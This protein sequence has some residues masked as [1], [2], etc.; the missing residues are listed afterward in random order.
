MNVKLEDILD[1]VRRGVR[2]ALAEDVGSGDITAELI[3]IDDCSTAKIIT[4]EDAVFCGKAWLDEC[5]SA[6]GGLDEIEWQVADGDAIHANQVLVTLRGNTRTLLTGERTALN[7]LQLLSGV[8]TK[9][10]DYAT[11]LGASKIKILDTRKTLPGLRLAQKYAVAVGGCHNHRIGL[12]DAFLVKE[13]H[14]AAAGGIRQAVTQARAIAPGKKIEVE[15]ENLIE[16]QEAIDAAA[17]VAM[18][19]NFDATMLEQAMAIDRKN[20]AFEISGNLDLERLSA[21]SN[22]NIDYCSFGDLTKNVQSID[23]SMR[24][25]GNN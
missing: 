25:I 22:L 15:T 17:D 21:I 14:I 20:T 12:Y 6:L 3:P 11:R 1:D 7:Y 9:A 8:A 13:N 2:Q 24:I 4:R 19:D 18:L 23:L 16:L 10:R 5:F